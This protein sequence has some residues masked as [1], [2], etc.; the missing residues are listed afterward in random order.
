MVFS[1]KRALSV[2]SALSLA[3]CMVM[4]CDD[5]AQE[6][7]PP[8][9]NPGVTNPTPNPGVTNPGVVTDNHYLSTCTALDNTQVPDFS[10]VGKENIVS[11]LASICLLGGNF[12]LPE[13]LDKPANE[14]VI[15]SSCFCY[16][17]ECE[18]TGYERP[19]QGVI[20]G[21][22]AVLE[23]YNGAVRSC[24][25][26]SNVSGIKPA[27][28]FPN[29]TCALSMSKCTGM[30]EDSEGKKADE[31]TICGFATFGDYSKKDQFLACP[32]NEVLVD[33][34]MNVEIV[35]LKRKAKLDVRACFQGCNTDADC[36]GAGIYDPAVGAESQTHCVET[37]TADASGKKARLCFDK[38]TV[39][40][41][42]SGINLVNAGDWAI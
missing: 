1:F 10:K 9:T 25:R 5:D 6:N 8:T 15:G 29:G 27:I 4:G 14:Q 34:V 18:Y 22:D 11:Y 26:S 41:S 42:E 20:Y 21:C 30:S 39:I 38:R 24:Y 16:G 17:E 13:F 37:D 33:F 32:N 12:T 19:E 3:S 31:A 23:E 2:L 40:D 36:V 28:Y 35:G 7:N